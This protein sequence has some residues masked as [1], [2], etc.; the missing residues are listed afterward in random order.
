MSGKYDDIINLPHHTSTKHP[1]MTRS[2]RAAQFAPFA[3][4]T[5]LDDEMEETARLTDK[6]IILDEEQKQVINRELL[7][8]KNNPQ[9]DIPVI[10]T[11]FKS[12]GRKEGGAY[13][14][15]EVRIKKIDEIN[16]K[17]I[18]S[19]YSEIEI[20]DLFSVKRAVK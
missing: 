3:A 4:L 14:E 9:R 12:D 16:R 6:K 1:R 17:L 19:D 10:I 5:G 13:I 20:D 18:L 15:K 2:A 7:F 8:I 11:F